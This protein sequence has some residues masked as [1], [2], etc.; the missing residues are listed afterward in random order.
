MLFFGNKSEQLKLN[1][2]GH[3]DSEFSLRC[4][5]SSSLW[6]ASRNCWGI[7]ISSSI[8]KCDREVSVRYSRAQLS[9]FC[10]PHV[11]NH[12]KEQ[13][14]AQLIRTCSGLK[15][16]SWLTGRTW[17]R[18]ASQGSVCKAGWKPR[19]GT[20]MPKKCYKVRILS[21]E[22]SGK[23]YFPLSTQVTLFN[24]VSSSYLLFL[25]ANIDNVIYVK[26]KKK[27]HVPRFLLCFP[28]FLES[29]INTWMKSET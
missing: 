24:Y 25:L 2:Q 9:W 28:D 1:A 8:L 22:K 29:T 15:R 21:H 23:C 11:N 10:R 4:R 13:G 3:G 27:K 5:A 19:Q 12:C 14:T 20:V 18:D 6:R 26:K 17:W 7:L 16:S